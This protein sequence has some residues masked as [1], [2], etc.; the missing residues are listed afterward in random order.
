VPSSA[1]DWDGAVVQD[2]TLSVC[3]TPAPTRGWTRRFRTVL[4][5]LDRSSG[6]WDGIKLKR[7]TITASELREGSESKLRHLLDSVIVE[8]GGDP[9]PVRAPGPEDEERAALRARDLRMT[10]AVRRSAGEA[11]P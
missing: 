4:G 2:G 9:D 8:L 5:V 7:G 3:V 1:I 10:E 6:D 11:R